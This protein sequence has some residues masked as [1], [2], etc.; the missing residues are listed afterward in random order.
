MAG[1]ISKTRTATLILLGCATV[2]VC[3][4]AQTGPEAVQ[5]IRSAS[6][7]TMSPKSSTDVGTQSETPSDKPLPDVVA[8]MHD[9]E[10][11][12]RKSESVERDYIYHSVRTEHEIDSHGQVKKT[13]VT[14]LDHFW[15]NGVPVRR[16][17]KKDGKALNPDE[18]AKENERI[19]KIAAKARDKRDKADDK[20]KET[21]SRGNEEITVSRL[22]ELGSFTGARRVQLNGRDTIAVD[23]AGDPKAKTRNRS[24]DVIKDLVGTAWIDER[25]HVLARV[26]GRF[27]NAFKI[28]G[29]LIANIQKDTRFSMVQ[30]KVNDE[31]WLPARLEGQGAARALLFFSFNGSGLIVNSDYRKFRATS[32]ILPGVA[33]VPN[34]AEAPAPTNP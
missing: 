33:E 11:N 24:E 15:L 17:V 26:E 22:L 3:A 7:P 32:T 28:G 20:G 34:A 23:F 6:Q 29:G 16:V 9:V 10:I 19:D 12:Q 14:E 2:C 27:A 31:V 30:T 21:D 8:M 5:K 18:I 1:L 25:D 4:H 13:T